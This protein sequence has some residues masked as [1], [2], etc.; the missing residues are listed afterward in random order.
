MRSTIFKTK[1]D[2]WIDTASTSFIGNQLYICI[3]VPSN[4]SSQSL[5]FID[6]N[7]HILKKSN[8]TSLNADVFHADS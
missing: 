8:L 4:T 7:R 6:D 2:H 5:D 3:L 1:S